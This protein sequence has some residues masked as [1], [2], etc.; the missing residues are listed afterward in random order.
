MNSSVVDRQQL[1]HAEPC[2]N[3]IYVRSEVLPIGKHWG[4]ALHASVIGS[5]W[6]ML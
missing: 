3:S 1:N 4:H 2:S 6:I 5:N